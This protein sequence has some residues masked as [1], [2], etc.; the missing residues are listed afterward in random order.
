M[1]KQLK[2]CCPEWAEISSSKMI[3]KPPIRFVP[4]VTEYDNDDPTNSFSLYLNLNS[5]PDSIVKKRKL[6][7]GEEEGAKEPE[8]KESAPATAGSTIRQT[9]KKLCTGD[10]EAYIRWHKQLDQVITSKPCD[11][12]RAKFDL[13][14]MM[15]Y[16][17]LKDT[18]QEIAE[19]TRKASVTKDKLS[20]DG[21]K[22]SVTAPRGF[23][24]TA[25]RIA[26]DKLKEHFFA[27]FAARKEKAY[28][29]AGLKKPRDITVRQMSARLRVMNSY[30]SRFPP[31]ENSSFSTGELI[32]I[33]IGM[34][35]HSWV[36]SMIS[37]GIEPREM[38]FSG[39]IDHLVNLESTVSAAQTEERP[40]K[41]QK[42]SENHN[43]SDRNKN[44]G[45]RSAKAQ[46]PKATSAASCAKH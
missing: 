32:E 8:E 31:P 40:A 42:S 15:L 21:T 44:P 33:V 25:F 39:L 37:A 27:K 23:S 18:W 20:Q 11:T 35:P 1:D 43:K 6:E 2:D 19:S 46:P 41:K 24:N 34:I 28:M 12:N 45:V 3:G 26:T 36:T 22:T 7:L 13:V 4:K 38:T 29:R 5:V 10:A 14:D 16:G 30:L 17:D 9:I